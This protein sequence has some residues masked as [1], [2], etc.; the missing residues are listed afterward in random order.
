LT[1]STL[2]ALNASLNAT[3]G[4]LL[5]AGWYF[6]HRGDI[7]KHRACMVGAFFVSTAFL[8]SYVVYHSLHGSTPFP[9]TGWPRAAYL[10]LLVS[11]VLLAVA[12][13][14]LALVTLFRAAGGDF[15]RHR[16]IARFTWPLW[17]YVSVTGVLVYWIL[18][19]VYAA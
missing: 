7:A 11:H 17:M 19:R 5:A 4:I 3:S 1:V 16:A 15:A 12:L 6:I 2:P 18:Y 8:V 9:G 10:G 14:P 13:V